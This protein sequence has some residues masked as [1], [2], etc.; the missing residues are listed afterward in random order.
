MNAYYLNM[1]TNHIIDSI[2]KN[3]MLDKRMRTLK[4]QNIIDEYDDQHPLYKRPASM[5]G[6][7]PD[8]HHKAIIMLLNLRSKSIKLEVDTL[9]LM[10]LNLFFFWGHGIESLLDSHLYFVIARLWQ[11]SLW[12]LGYTVNI[13]CG[14]GELMWLSVDCVFHAIPKFEI[15]E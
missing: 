8:G 15:S 6:L 10:Q 2:F 4:P 7:N 13:T 3:R 1:R 9:L 12:L 5:G 14:I 11:F